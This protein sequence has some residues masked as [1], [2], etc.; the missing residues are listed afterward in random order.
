MAGVAERIGRA[1]TTR[2]DRHLKTVGLHHPVGGFDAHRAGD[3]HRAVPHH[4]HP[5]VVVGAHGLS[6]RITTRR[7]LR[8]PGTI[9][10]L[11]CIQS[12]LLESTGPNGIRCSATTSALSPAAH[13]SKSERS[14]SAN[15][16]C[17]ISSAPPGHSSA[18]ADS[19]SGPST[20]RP[21]TPPSQDRGGEPATVG[22][23]APGGVGTYGGLTTT[24]SNGAAVS[25]YIH[26]PWRTST[27]TPAANALACAHRTAR[28]QMSTAVTP[29]A[30]SSAAAIATTP[31]PVHRSSTRLRWARPIDAMTPTSNCESSWGTYTPSAIGGRPRGRPTDRSAQVVNSGNITRGYPTPGVA[32]RRV[33]P[34]PAGGQAPRPRFIRRGSVRAHH[35]RFASPTR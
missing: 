5:P 8:Q 28:G 34:S 30:P 26:G 21:S 14:T 15:S 29:A 4:P 17:T 10:P 7:S 33:H 12:S 16:D 13:K 25:P 23:A 1:A 2:A 3:Q 11:C 9:R 19:H 18:P 32:K 6:A 20:A 27:S 22:G 31:E 35:E 24:T